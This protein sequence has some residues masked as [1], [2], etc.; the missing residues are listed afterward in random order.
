[1]ILGFVF[2]WTVES[3]ILVGALSIGLLLIVFG[4]LQHAFN[5]IF[6]KNCYKCK[7]CYL[8][9]VPGCGD[10]ATYKCDITKKNRTIRKRIDNEYVFCNSYIEK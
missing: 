2:V 1:M 4:L 3:I 6:K 8:H 5:V 9:S 10:G 7:H